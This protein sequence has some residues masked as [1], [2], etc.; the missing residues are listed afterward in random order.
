MQYYGC[1]NVESMCV[2]LSSDSLSVNL[3]WRDQYFLE[4]EHHVVI[5][6]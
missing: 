6:L 1:S 3:Q 2:R 5:P 4:M